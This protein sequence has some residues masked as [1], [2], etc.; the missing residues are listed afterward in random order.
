MRF[1]IA[2]A[3]LSLSGCAQFQEAI[4]TGP[5]A[6]YR[7]LANMDAKHALAIAEANPG[8]FNPVEI[9]C[10]QQI[11]AGTDFLAREAMGAQGV[12][13][14]LAKAKVLANGATPRACLAAL[15]P[16]P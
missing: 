11:V 10:L 4:Q 5:L 13:T 8:A 16:V 12:L 1:L 6:Q 3:L 2:L 14:E 7:D 15:G 9:A